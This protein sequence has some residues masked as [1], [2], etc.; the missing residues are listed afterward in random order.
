MISAPL[1]AGPTK[2]T[3]R[4]E[5]FESFVLSNLRRPQTLDMISKFVWVQ[6]QELEPDINDLHPLSLWQL[7][8]RA[9]RNQSTAPRASRSSD[10]SIGESLSRVLSQLPEKHRNALVALKSERLTN[11]QISERLV[12]PLLVVEVLVAQA[13]ALLRVFAVEPYCASDPHTIVVGR[14][15]ILV[16]Q[17]AAEWF[18]RT[19]VSRERPNHE[20]TRW[21]RARALHVREFL[22]I[23]A[24][25]RLLDR[26]CAP[27]S[28]VA[29]AQ[30]H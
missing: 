18:G 22:L 1:D 12:L 11:K 15:E 13:R 8:A 29:H 27:L 7:A 26:V 19:E 16:S 28:N 6:L 17:C 2:T 25:D 21:I 10:A 23:A 5:A 24:W 30:A 14:D 9:S 3:P 20:F 4:D